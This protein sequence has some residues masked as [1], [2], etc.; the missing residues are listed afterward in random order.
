MFILGVIMATETNNSQLTSDVVKMRGAVAVNPQADIDN[1][2]KMLEHS[3]GEAS[4]SGAKSFSTKLT[5]AKHS[6]APWEDDYDEDYEEDYTGRT[7]P[8]FGLT[9][10]NDSKLLREID[11][12]CQDLLDETANV[13]GEVS[14]LRLELTE[15]RN[16]MKTLLAH[17]KGIEEQI[18]AL[19]STE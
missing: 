7:S 8:K 1:L 12:N 5:S 15:M 16:L 3:T 9:S 11:G 19:R 10:Q 14:E 17:V 6:Y 2:F 13:R 18:R 4:S